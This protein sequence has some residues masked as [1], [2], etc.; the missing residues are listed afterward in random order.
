MHPLYNLEVDQDHSYVVEG[1][2]VHNCDRHAEADPDG[3]GPGV[4]LPERAAVSHPQDLCIL[5][6]PWNR[7]RRSSNLIAAKYADETGDC[8]MTTCTV[9]GSIHRPDDT[10][11]YAATVGSTLVSGTA[12]L[13]TTYP[14]DGFVTT[15]ADGTF[16]VELHDRAGY[17]LPL[18]PAGR[19][20][21]FPALPSG[22]PDPVSIEVLRATYAPPSTAP[23][24]TI[25]DINTAVSVT[26]ASTSPRACHGEPGGTR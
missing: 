22:S 2:V 18:H 23:L 25:I 11:W 14:E 8:R 6:T 9:T 1:V 26:A 12:T 15:A 19:G 3:L 10:P 16:A 5:P 21:L 17:A 4:Y 7:G 20:Q 24:P 13:D